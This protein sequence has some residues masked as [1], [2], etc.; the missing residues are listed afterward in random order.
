MA[1]R[2]TAAAPTAE[3]PRPAEPK[4]EP[5][6]VTPRQ[7]H[8]LLGVY[9]PDGPPPAPP[10]RPG[11]AT[12][13]D[14]GVSIRDVR[15]KHPSLFCPP[16]WTDGQAFA[17]LTDVRKWRQVKLG[18]AD[19]GQPFAEQVKALGGGDEPPPARELIVFLVVHLLATGERLEIPRLRCRDVLPSGRR[20]V[21]GPFH[22]TGI[23]IG[24]V[25]DRWASPGIGL[26]AVFTPPAARKRR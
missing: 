24:N 7:A 14:P 21:V 15:R 6:V 22:G 26:A 13:W 25:S 4:E 10:S 18:A 17:K 8:E 23:E 20:V 19:P 5:R 16:D 2:K 12:F 11:Y 9:G 3:K 1:K